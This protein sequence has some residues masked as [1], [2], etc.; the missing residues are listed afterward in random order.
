MPQNTPRGYSYPCYGDPA[1]FPAQLQDLAQD[2]D[3]DMQA[4][5]S[6]IGDARNLPPSCKATSVTSV[7]I[8]AGATV[9]L[10]F[11]TEVYDNANM[12]TPLVPDLTAPV[13]GLYLIAFNVTFSGP[14]NGVRMI[15]TSVNGFIRA[16]Q[17]RRRAGTSTQMTV[18]AS[19][20]SFAAAG[21][22]I[23]IFAG[24]SV[25]TTATSYSVSVT[26]LTGTTAL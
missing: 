9:Q 22:P 3:A 13:E 20:L 2:V 8:A 6:N 17:A 26:R 1:N 12:F 19:M 14:N 4:I 18:N 16:A 23:R 15:N 7:A 25:A 5:I 21:N 24:S 11:S 10:T